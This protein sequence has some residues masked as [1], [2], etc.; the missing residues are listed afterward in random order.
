MFSLRFVHRLNSSPISWRII[1]SSILFSFRR[2]SPYTME[3]VFR[4]LMKTMKFRTVF[5]PW[6]YIFS[7]FSFLLCFHPTIMSLPRIR[8]FHNLT[9]LKMYSRSQLNLLDF[10][11]KNIIGRLSSATSCGLSPNTSFVLGLSFRT[12]AQYRA[13]LCLTHC[14]VISWRVSRVSSPTTAIFIA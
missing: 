14:Q 7:D 6:K 3:S 11:N 13:T 10:H 1:I 12:L 9:T 5:V 4:I 2:I 8:M